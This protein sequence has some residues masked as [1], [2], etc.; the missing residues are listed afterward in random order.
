MHAARRAALRL[1]ALTA[2]ALALIAL[3]ASS[4]APASPG[5]PG[6]GPGGRGLDLTVPP[7]PKGPGTAIGGIALSPYRAGQDPNEGQHPSA[8]EVERDVA[9]LAPRTAA[10]RTY[11]ASGGGGLVPEA[12]GRRGMWV[13]QGAWLSGGAAADE[14]ELKALA[15]LAAAHP[16]IHSVLAGNE[17]VLHGLLEP[18]ALVAFMR[19]AGE[20]TGLPVSTAEP[21]HVWLEHPE[22]AR[23]ADF[24]AAH[25]LP[26]WDGVPAEEAA[27]YVLRRCRELEARYPGKPVVIA[28]TGWPSEG[29]AR[30]GA[31]P[32]TGTQ[33]LFV[34]RFLDLAH[35]ERLDYFLLEA[36]D[37][38]WKRRREG[39][40]G[41]AWGL[42]DAGRIPKPGLPPLPER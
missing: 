22:L 2:P 8:A 26:Y 35:R 3:G 36:F 20:E 17:T 6:P 12:A 16:S 14:A 7:M 39:A 13:M 25:I 37:Q 24:L 29:P 9:L 41:G 38:P 19:R 11:G 18:A 34:A 42:W 15:R 21:W 1:A 32:S 30:G 33:A 10:L 4:P 28:E 40:V 31:I 27:G 23:E 5:L